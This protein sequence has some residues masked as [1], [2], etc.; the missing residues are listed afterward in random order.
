MPRKTKAKAKCKC[1]VK[2][3]CSNKI[4]TS[5]VNVEKQKQRPRVANSFSTFPRHQLVPK[6]YSQFGAN[7]WA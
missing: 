6:Y 5:C 3:S 2:G 1:K 7:T 4:P